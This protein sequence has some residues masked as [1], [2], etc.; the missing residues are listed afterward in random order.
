MAGREENVDI[1]AQRR[2]TT[3]CRRSIVERG[4]SE[5]YQR[6]PVV[7]RAWQ[8]CSSKPSSGGQSPGSGSQSS[9]AVAS[10]RQSPAGLISARQRLPVLGRVRQSPIHVGFGFGF[11]FR[12]TLKFTARYMRRCKCRS[13]LSRSA[14]Q[15]TLLMNLTGC[16]V[17][18]ALLGRM[19]E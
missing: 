16:E 14:I 3:R 10:A 1:N 6:R 11:T 9:T 7:V 8:Q 5:L 18:F 12:F 4:V 19:A 2:R 13:T 15:G 17:R